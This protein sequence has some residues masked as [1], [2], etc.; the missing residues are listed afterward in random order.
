M[1]YSWYLEYY[2]ALFQSFFQSQ[3]LNLNP[4]DIIISIVCLVYAIEGYLIGFFAAAFDLASFLLSFILALKFYRFFGEYF[5]EVFKM[6]PGFANVLSFFIIAFLS[7]II[8]NLVLKKIF[9]LI[10][11]SIRKRLPEDFE[12]RSLFY[13]Y[14]STANHLFGIVP[15]LISSLILF[16]FIMSIIAA[17][18]FSPFLKNIVSS[19][20][21][22]N[23]LVA[24]TQ[25]LEKELDN[26]FGG[27]ISETLNFITIEPKS[28]ESVNLNF[29]VVNTTVD[30]DAEEKMLE[31]IN[32]ERKKK[33]LNSLVMD[34]KLRELARS[35]AK[36]MFKKGYFSHE[37][38]DGLSPFD[39]MER[40]NIG[41]NSAGENLALSPNVVIAMQ[42]L[43]NSKG[44][45]ANIL[46]PNFGRIGIGV[47]D[48]G[49]YGEMFVQEFTN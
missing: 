40:D 4:L 43:M 45:R 25:V 36:D 19:S 46:S 12:K 5:V 44:H 27:A 20:K 35:Y 6:P 38:Q 33:G 9:N 15:A 2:T 14:F 10:R 39:R 1:S 31:M 47:M 16:S 3:S 48:G 29:R 49:I 8:I 28:D 42:G 22:G 26:I 24:N 37:S 11:I 34:E 7:E 21:I 18:P 13:A 23:L 17:F 41:F 30:E 32:I